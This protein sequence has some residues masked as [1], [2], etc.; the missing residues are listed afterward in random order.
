MIFVK[1]IDDSKILSQSDLNDL[2]ISRKEEWG[3]AAGHREIG[4][5]AFGHREFSNPVRHPDG[6]SLAL[7][8]SFSD[9]VVL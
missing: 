5:F 7:T 2:S 6:N 4:E 9:I 8:L 1:V 3:G